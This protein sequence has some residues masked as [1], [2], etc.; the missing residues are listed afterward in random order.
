MQG[1][2][3]KHTATQERQQDLLCWCLMVEVKVQARWI[4]ESIKMACVR[5]TS[6]FLLK[7][8]F[9]VKPIRMFLI[10]EWL[11]KELHHNLK[12]KE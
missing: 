12:Q 8:H 3:V 9:S 10:A 7:Y 11:N 4:I 6:I 1:S 5:S 2:H